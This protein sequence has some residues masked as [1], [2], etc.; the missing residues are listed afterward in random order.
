MGV[1]TLRAI[2]DSATDGDGNHD[3][4]VGYQWNNEGYTRM[5]DNLFGLNEKLTEEIDFS[6]K[7]EE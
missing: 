2:D 1:V 3:C 6:E 7:S 4:D 5:D